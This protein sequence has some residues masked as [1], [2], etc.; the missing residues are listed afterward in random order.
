[1]VKDLTVVFDCNI[2]VTTALAIGQRGDFSHLEEAAI[3][4]PYYE[5]NRVNAFR[6]ALQGG[7][8]PVR[9]HVGWSNHIWQTV[10]HVLTNQYH[11]SIDDALSF[12][13]LVQM[14]LIDK[15]NGYVIDPVGEGFIRMDD[16]EDSVVYE[17]ARIMTNHPPVMIVSDDISFIQKAAYYHDHPQGAT[18]FIVATT[19]TKFCTFCESLQIA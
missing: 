12:V 9:F 16:H 2:Y 14:E 19:S 4:R 11:W 10:Q 5:R 6:W 3:R 8:G 7:S 1:M 15:T 18:A 17:T 13:D